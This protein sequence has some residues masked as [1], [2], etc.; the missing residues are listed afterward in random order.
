MVQQTITKLPLDEWRRYA[1]MQPLQ[2]WGVY[3]PEIESDQSATDSAWF[4]YEWQRRDAISREELANAIAQAE[5]DIEAQLKY[6]LL[7]SWELDE[8][9]PTTRPT[10]PEYFNLNNRDVRGFSQKVDANWGWMIS[11]GIRSKAVVEAGAA[12]VYTNT[13]PPAGYDNLATVT[14]TV[15]AGTDPQ[16]LHVYYPGQSGADQYEIRP[17]KVS[18][19]GTTA[20]ITFRREMALIL[21][22]FENYDVDGLRPVLGTDDAYFL[23]EVDVYLV[24]NDPSQQAT[25]LW[26]PPFCGSCGG[27]GCIACAYSAQTGCIQTFGDPRWG[28]VSYT[29]AEWD[30]DSETFQ[31]RTLANGRQPDIVRLWYYAGLRD[32]SLAT[33]LV[34]MSP[35]WA[36]IVAAL[37][38]S[39]LDREPADRRAAL[40]WQYWA[41]D[42]SYESGGDQVSRYKTPRE[43]LDN[44]FGQHRGE[45]YAWNEI[46]KITRDQGGP[47]GRGVRL[48]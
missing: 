4:Q 9:Q 28:I 48:R 20:T 25:M 16:T 40:Y 36:R 39:R 26:N 23:T 21:D 24:T 34:T 18:I 44:P 11:G 42:L 35:P 2:F 45:V 38:A 5:A 8:W 43:I 6:R 14:V 27:S 41:E 46:I 7:P 37:A 19:T 33:P 29:P 17:V 31:R 12:I 10:V 30:A 3:I 1:G 13:I 47:V 32:K 15:V 22:A